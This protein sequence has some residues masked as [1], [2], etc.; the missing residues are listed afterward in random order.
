[1]D[2][3]V[4][5][6][7]IGENAPLIRERI[8]AGLD[9]LGLKLHRGRNT[10]NAARIST[11]SA[12]VTVRVIRTDEELVIARLVA[13]LLRLDGASSASPLP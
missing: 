1:L 9:F 10:R 3:L 11:D 13:R 2:T 4:L 7:G 6:G 5:A 8:C 12:R